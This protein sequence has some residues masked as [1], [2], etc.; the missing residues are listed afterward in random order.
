MSTNKL[1]STRVGDSAIPTVTVRI[2]M[3][4]NTKSP[5]PELKSASR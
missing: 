5:K 1:M 4:K 2:P 3:P